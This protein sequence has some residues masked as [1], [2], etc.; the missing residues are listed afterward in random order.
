MQNF[1]GQGSNLHHSSDN[2]RSLTDWA[3]S[4]LLEYPF[5]YNVTLSIFHMSKL[6]LTEVGLPLGC[7]ARMCSA[8]I[9]TDVCL[10]TN[11]TLSSSSPGRLLGWGWQTWGSDFWTVFYSNVNSWHHKHTPRPASPRAHEHVLEAG[12]CIRRSLPS[13]AWKTSGQKHLHLP[14]FSFCGIMYLSFRLPNSGVPIQEMEIKKIRN[15]FKEICS[16]FMLSTQGRPSWSNLI[17]Y[18]ECYPYDRV[19][20]EASGDTL[21]ARAEILFFK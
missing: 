14:W 5:K 4:E 7:M 12:V 20:F 16:F 2:A 3:T 9:Y 10:E 19:A 8:R 13:S 6:R 15:Q 1:P 11:L 21:V 17:A 18:E